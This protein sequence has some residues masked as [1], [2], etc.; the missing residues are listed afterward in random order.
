M[1][2][3]I[4]YFR[5]S[6]TD[7]EKIKIAVEESSKRNDLEYLLI[8]M[9][10]IPDKENFPIKSTPCLVVGPY[11][12]KTPI[13]IRDIDIAITT[14]ARNQEKNQRVS[15][16]EAIIKNLAG[17]FLS[18]YYPTIIAFVL[19][20]FISGAFI[21]PYRMSMGKELQAVRIY[22]FYRIFCHQLAFRSY[23]ISGEQLYYPRAL[24]G[25]DG[26]ITY[27]DEFNDPVDDIEIA[28][29]IT[30]NSV[31][32]YKVALCQR[33]IAIYTSLAISAIL[34]QFLKKR[35]KPVRWYFWFLV[36]LI[37]IGL[38]GFSQIPGLSSGWPSWFPIREST[39]L[40]RSIT[41]FLFGGMTGL[42]MFPLMEESMAETNQQLKMN[43]VIIGAL[44]K[45]RNRNG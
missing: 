22:D 25:I 7:I 39:P 20:A 27:E 45:S 3:A 26:A 32:G 8:D 9:E 42:Y 5:E 41:G 1:R 35:I 11:T 12:L 10:S 18:N 24:A 2:R 28:S 23:F 13:N 16:K 21:A 38:D 17:I 30:G 19:I 14:A 44:A 34:F 43:R 37:P 33:D 40:L 6:D 15:L 36:A 4:L 29:E 31:S